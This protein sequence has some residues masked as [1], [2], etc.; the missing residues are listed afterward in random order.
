MAVLQVVGNRPGVGKTC[1]IGAVLSHL[2]ATGRSAAYFKPFS[3]DSQTDA[4]VAFISTHLLAGAGNPQEPAPVRFPGADA[5]STIL[6]GPDGQAIGKAVA[7]LARTAKAVLS[8]G[9]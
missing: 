6:G 8:R 1:L 9:I 3:S 7:D 4:D 5:S 2:A